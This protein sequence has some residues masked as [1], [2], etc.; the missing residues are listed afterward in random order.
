MRV[1][2][3]NAPMAAGVLPLSANIRTAWLFAKVQQLERSGELTS[4]K[5]VPW[6]EKTKSAWFLL[7]I[8][9]LTLSGL[10]IFQN[11]NLLMLQF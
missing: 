3:N 7:K 2:E 5:S 1:F 11:T 9:C 4:A 10:E 6:F 8:F